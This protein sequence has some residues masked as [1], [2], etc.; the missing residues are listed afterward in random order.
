MSSSS[1]PKSAFR[2][3][4]R[5]ARGYERRSKPQA[6]LGRPPAGQAGVTLMELLVALA[7]LITVSAS[8]SLIFRGVTRAWRTGQ[9][10]TERYQ[11]ARLLTDLFNRELSSCVVDARYPF[12]GL[13]AGAESPKE[14][15]RFDALFFVGTLPGRA[16]LIERGYWVDQDDWFMCHDQ[17]PADGDYVATGTDERCGSDITDFEVTYFDGTAWL[18]AWDGR[19]DGAQA[20]RVPKAVQ[21][22]LVVGKSPGERFETIVRIPTS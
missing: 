11:Q 21:I 9:L 1:R 3:L 8:A 18:D 4:P 5:L 10:R 12:I 2:N 15:S 19:P 16:G 22:S 13:D 17:E 6:P 7:I 14:G 20:G